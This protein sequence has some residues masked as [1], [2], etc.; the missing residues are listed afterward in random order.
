MA[1]RWGHSDRLFSWAPKSLH[2]VTAATKLRHLLLGRKAMT[3]LDSIF[4]SRD[5][6]LPTKVCL[7]KAMIFPV[8][9]MWGLDYKESWLLKNWCFWTV[10]EKTL[11]SPLDCKE[12]QPLNQFSSVQFSHSV[13]S[14]SQRPHELQQARPPCPSQTSRVNLNSR[15]SS[16]WCHPAIS[17]SVAA[18]SPA[19]NSSQHQSFPMSQLFAWGGQSIGVSALAAFLPINTHD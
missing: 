18:F 4:K 1:N 12:I 17:S 9:M 10:L 13:V 3:N 11:E 7:V 14:D 5:I 2:I 8:V 19:P 16:Q 15:P 6:T